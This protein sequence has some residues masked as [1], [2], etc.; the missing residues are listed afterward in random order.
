MVETQV[1]VQLQRAVF[2]SDLIEPRDPVFNVSRRIP[3]ALLE[4]VF[5]RIEI[6]LATGQRLIL[7]KFVSAVDAVE[8]G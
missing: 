8:A 7:A 2:S 4:L 6:F 1:I 3:V 5:L